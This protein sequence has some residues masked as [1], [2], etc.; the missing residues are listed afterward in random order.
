[1]DR[2]R[3]T[4]QRAIDVHPHGEWV[5]FEDYAPLRAQLVESRKRELLARDYYE[6]KMATPQRLS[7]LE[8][9]LAERERQLEAAREALAREIQRNRSRA[10]WASSVVWKDV[11]E[12]QLKIWRQ[13]AE[14]EIA[15]LT[16]PAAEQEPCPVCSGLG[17]DCPVCLQSRK[18]VAQTATSEKESLRKSGHA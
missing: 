12:E 1:M 18:D 2:F 7:K 6:C 3:V 16:A 4:D 11:P 9:K 13:I 14:R 15:A 10:V 17:V 8:E 5:R